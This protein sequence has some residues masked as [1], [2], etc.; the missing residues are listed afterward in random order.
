VAPPGIPAVAGETGYVTMDKHAR[1][2]ET[3]AMI[4]RPRQGARPRPTWLD[5]FVVA[6]SVM[7]ALVLVLAFLHVGLRI[8]P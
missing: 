1:A 3:A 5:W 8:G 6:V 7:F 2:G 4:R